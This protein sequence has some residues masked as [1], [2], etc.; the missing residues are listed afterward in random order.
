MLEEDKWN[1]EK[2]LTKIVQHSHSPVNQLS[3]SHGSINK[4]WED[5]DFLLQQIS[6]E[7]FANNEAEIA[8]PFTTIRS[9][10]TMATA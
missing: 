10:F 5:V 2:L 1:S 6:L 4:T 9:V 8:C 7:D 3:V